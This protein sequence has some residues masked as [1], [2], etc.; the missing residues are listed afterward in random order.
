MSTLPY[1]IHVAFCDPFGNIFDR[2]I[3]IYSVWFLSNNDANP[4]CWCF[5]SVLQNL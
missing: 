2:V 5:L 3:W 4:G 1:E